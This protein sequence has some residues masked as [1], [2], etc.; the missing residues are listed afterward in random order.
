MSVDTTTIKKLYGF[1]YNECAHPDCDKL[2]V[3][4]DTNTGKPV[5]YGEIAHIR[6]QK[7]KS[8]RFDPDMTKEEIDHFDNVFLLCA[9]HH[10]QI[11]QEG[12]GEVYTPDVLR[13]WKEQHTLN[14]I[15][16][17]AGEDREW[18]FGGQTINF[19]VD[20]EK[21]SLSYWIN[22][23]GE[24]NFHT[25]EQLEQTDAARDFSLCMSQLF[26]LVGLIDQAEGEPADP[27]N[28]TQNDGYMRMLKRDS[29]HLTQSFSGKEKYQ[30]LAH[31]MYATLEACPDIT[32]KELAELGTEKR[33]MKTTLIIGEANDERIEETKEVLKNNKSKPSE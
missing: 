7:P 2:L 15:A 4:M 20:G 29:E 16:I 25:D 28:I 11:D 24:M 10:H 32:L 12:A 17:G 27:S 21:V 9:I 6:G 26:S 14:K 33:Q 1:S 8:E 3:E 19:E 23:Q 5:N 31:R 18:V 30:S 22:A 13:Q